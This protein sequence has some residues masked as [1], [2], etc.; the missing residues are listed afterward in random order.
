MFNN[1][2]VVFHLAAKN[3]ISDCQLDPIETADINITGTVNIFEAC[4]KADVKKIIFAESSALYEG[5]T[6]F[7][8]PENSEAPESFYAVSK[9]AEKY[10]AVNSPKWNL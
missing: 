7:P 4:K 1:V 9:Y 3:C 6:V 8:T 5:S 2:D 10:F